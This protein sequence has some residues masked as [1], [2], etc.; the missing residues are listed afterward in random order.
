MKPYFWYLLSMMM[1]LMSAAV[2]AQDFNS[3]ANEKKGDTKHLDADGVLNLQDY[4][5]EFI[6]DGLDDDFYSG[7]SFGLPNPI[8][9][10][11]PA[12]HNFRYNRVDGLYLGLEK[13]RMSH[14]LDD[15]LGIE[16]INVHGQLGYSFGRSAFQYAAGF[17][18]PIG[19]SKWLILGGEYYN[20]TATEDY[21]RTGINENSVSSLFAGFDFMDYFNKEGIGLYGI[22]QAGQY[23]E[24][25]ASY[26]DDRYSSLDLSTRSSI[27]GYRS[28]FRF[29]PALDPGFNE[30]SLQAFNLGL[31]LNPDQRIRNNYFS[32]SLSLRAELASFGANSGDFSFNKY[33]AESKS[34]INLDQSTLLRWRLMGGAVTGLAPV[35]KQFALGG[36]GSIRSAGFKSLIGN[37]MFLSNLELEFGRSRSS[38]SGSSWVDLRST[39]LL[40]FLDSGWA[41]MSGELINEGSPAVGLNEFTLDQLVHS[42]GAGIGSG[43][44]RVEIATPIGGSPGQTVLWF[45]F[46]PTF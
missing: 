41:N 30:I 28:N 23:L 25:A 9:G 31:T 16:G 17:D 22:I 20:T 4:H 13:E 6:M 19:K 7:S 36:I 5:M 8:Y 14:R 44:W 15:F 26:N 2:S 33:Q 35:F 12:L 24:L 45:R 43:K 10:A 29:N 39:F 38:H 32:T 21:W 11:Y 42:A 37:Q 3:P 34:V 46:N 27:F 40:L 1:V 18:K